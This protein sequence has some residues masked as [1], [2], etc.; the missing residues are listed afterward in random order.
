MPAQ[1]SGQDPA[2]DLTQK[3]RKDILDHLLFLDDAEIEIHC[4]QRFA[5]LYFCMKHL[6]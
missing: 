6:K 5:M 1:L 2:A 3:M 4:L